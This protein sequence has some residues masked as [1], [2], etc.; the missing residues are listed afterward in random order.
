[1]TEETYNG[2]EMICWIRESPIPDERPGDFL[3]CVFI[4]NGYLVAPTALYTKEDMTWTNE[5]LDYFELEKVYVG[6]AFEK[7]IAD[8]SANRKIGTEDALLVLQ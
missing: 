5:F 1:M 8:V 3:S 2:K 7:K 4:D 6:N